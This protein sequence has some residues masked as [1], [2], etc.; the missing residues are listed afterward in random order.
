MIY[1][2]LQTPAHAAS[3][4]TNTDTLIQPLS[5]IDIHFLHKLSLSGTCYLRPALKL[6]PQKLLRP[7]CAQP[8]R[9][10]TLPPSTWY[11][12]RRTV[13]Y[14]SW[15]WS[16]LDASI[17]V[18][19]LM[20]DNRCY[21]TA[22]SRWSILNSINGSMIDS[23]FLWIVPQTTKIQGVFQKHFMSS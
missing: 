23:R 18:R 16:W 15:S 17:I 1:S 10:H 22:M 9:A 5:N 6:I 2:S 4:S 8:P 14:P 21:S 20:R 7:H 19:F 3:T 12:S 11:S 13:D